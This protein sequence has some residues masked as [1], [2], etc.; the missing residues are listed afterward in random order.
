MIKKY[1]LL[2]VSLFVSLSVFSQERN[3]SEVINKMLSACDNLKS[4]GFVLKS[5]ERLKDGAL[6]ESEVIVK[7]QRNPLKI[8]VYCVNPNPGAEGLWRIGELN[9]HVL[10]NPNGFP[11]FNLRLNTHHLLLRKGQHHTIED[12]GF[13]YIS[14]VFKHYLEKSEK[15]ILKKFSLQGNVQFDGRNCIQLVYENPEF[16]YEVYR[17]SHNESLTKIANANF[18]NDYML[19][20]IN[21]E[22][23]GYDEVK[24]GQA[25]KLPVTYGKKIVL[26]LDKSTYLP[27]VQMIYDE[28]GLYEKYEFKSFLLNPKF[29][30]DDFNPENKKYGF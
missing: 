11:F 7:L 5:T 8:Y 25:I 22:L 6:H 9:N 14:N 1:F 10:V 29:D 30:A 15:E 28:H 24:A 27:L 2:A 12:L 17:S 18:V 20:C 16:T 4:S 23:K 19:L 3:V 13:D 21:K 26:Y